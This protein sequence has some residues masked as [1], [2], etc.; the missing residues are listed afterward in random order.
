MPPVFD[1]SLHRRAHERADAGAWSELAEFLHTLS[2]EKG[3][4]ELRVLYAEALIRLGQERA[5]CDWL[6]QVIP[7]LDAEADR[8]NHR[9][10]I[11]LFGVAAFTLG[12]LAE[13]GE[14]FTTALDLASR[15]D[16]LL[17]FARATNNLGAIANLQGRH[18]A[19]LG[20]YRLAVPA[21]QRLGQRRGLA[22]SYHNMAITHRDLGS[23]DEA[24]EHERRA[25]DYAVQGT[26]PRLAAMG[27]IGRAEIALRRGDPELA[28]GTAHRAAVELEQLE[29]RLNEADARRLEGAAAATRA[30]HTEAAAAFARALAIARDR[31]FALVEAE[32]LRDR[33]IAYERRRA[34]AESRAD[35][36]TAILI[37]ERLG[38]I[39]EVVALRARF[40]H[41]A[42]EPQRP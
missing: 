21:Y 19:A 33:A 7:A 9:R 37:F 30:R 35:A 5:A 18:T 2:P 36:A 28:E 13:A 39:A 26:A 24:D 31:G 25:I 12:D 40:P 27:R 16:D 15:Q 20:H 29:D 8:T 23:L 42:S 41:D 38:A 32:T 3:S 6:K 14:A 10:A 11:N 34:M 22:E 4:G 1:E 17:L